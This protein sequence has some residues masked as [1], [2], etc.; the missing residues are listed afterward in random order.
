ME[1]LHH[2][3]YTP[4]PLSV[5][6]TK[7]NKKRKQ[8]H[9]RLSAGL[10]GEGGTLGG[11]PYKRCTPL[12]GHIMCSV[13][14]ASS[15]PHGAKICFECHVLTQQVGR[16][17]AFWVTV[18]MDLFAFFVDFASKWKQSI[19][20][21]LGLANWQLLKLQGWAA[22]EIFEKVECIFIVGIW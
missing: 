3:L 20:G 15:A 7:H 4:P 11:L 12:F 1:S 5:G 2:L 18:G 22:R 10:F 13:C 14:F 21:R 9:A 16:R 17:S 19:L 6:K 8:N